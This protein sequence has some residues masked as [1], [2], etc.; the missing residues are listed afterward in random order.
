[1]GRNYLADIPGNFFVA[2]LGSSAAIA[3][4]GA[5]GRLS[6]D[7]VAPANLKVLS[8]WKVGL[9]AAEVTVGTATSSASYRRTRLLNGGT[10]GTAA[11]IM[12]SLNATAPAARPGS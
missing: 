4:G 11:A 8:V 12:A 9:G 3:S 6:M 1:M 2:H 7:F 10:A 5:N